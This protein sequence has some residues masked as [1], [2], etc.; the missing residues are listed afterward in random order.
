M[1]IISH[2]GNVSGSDKSIENNPNQI[3][4]V[5][6]LGFDVEIDLHFH[7]NDYYLGHDEP[8]YLIDKYWLLNR[9]NNLWVHLKTLELADFAVVRELN[10]FWHEND[11]F[12]MTSKGIPWCYPGVYLKHG[13]SVVLTDEFI[14][15]DI[16]GV[17][18]DYPLMYEKKL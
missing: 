11:K 3:D 1:K 16:F 13:V 4:R 14:T 10:Y 18:T 8:Q 15:K 12:T 7:D 2:R 9:K 6:N 17:C 5:L